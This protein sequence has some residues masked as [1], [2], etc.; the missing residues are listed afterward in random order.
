MGRTRDTTKKDPT[1]GRG[2][3]KDP[4]PEKRSKSRQK[5]DIPTSAVEEHNKPVGTS[6]EKGKKTNKSI[7]RTSETIKIIPEPESPKL[8]TSVESTSLPS[9][10]NGNSTK[11]KSSTQAAKG[12]S[13][14]R[15]RPLMEYDMEKLDSASKRKKMEGK[16]EKES[17]LRNGKQTDTPHQVDSDSDDTEGQSSQ[18]VY[19]H[20][21]SGDE[22]SSD[23]D[24]SSVDGDAIDV[25]SLSTLAKTT[26]V[27]QKLERA[28]KQKV[29]W[30]SC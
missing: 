19:L 1:M 4:K 22:D 23:D 20:V 10:P 28:K 24:D 7:P 6:P 13:G 21:F 25:N 18:E 5:N 27:Q 11:A 15:K 8:P 16:P 9:Q 12:T 26:A 14:K 3:S 2:S 17:P 29:C 30:S